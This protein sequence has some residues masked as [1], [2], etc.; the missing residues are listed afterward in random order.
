M[1]MFQLKRI[2]HEDPI[3]RTFILFAQTAGA[4]KKYADALLYRVGLS[5]IKLTVL[6]VLASNGGTMTPSEI[7]HWTLKERH[8]ITTLV[9]RMKK[10][11]LV[12]VRRSR[13]DRRSVNITLTDTGRRLLEDHT[14]L[15][16]GIA[17]HIMESISEDD[18]ALLEK[19]LEVLRQN[20]EGALKSIAAPHSAKD[21]IV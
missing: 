6:R 11:G 13:R 20:A 2:E 19:L 18:A 4:V 3:L 15:S 5:S 14:P 8:N 16:I 21:S 17:D 1:K 10:Q 12:K 7:A 9:D